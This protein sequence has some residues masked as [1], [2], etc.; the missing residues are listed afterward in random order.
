MG[1]FDRGADG[2]IQ[3]LTGKDDKGSDVYVDKA[4]FMVNQK[5]YII[6]KEGHLCTR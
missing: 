6:N 3:M 1:V 4:G 2:N 5:G